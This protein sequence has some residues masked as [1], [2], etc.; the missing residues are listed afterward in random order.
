MPKR[1]STVKLCLFLKPTYIFI[2]VYV[3]SN[4]V[5][6]MKGLSYMK[7]ELPL[8]GDEGRGEERRLP[9]ERVRNPQR[10]YSTRS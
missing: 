1:F 8:P 9:M 4:N 10:A 2:Q 7:A 5:G 6:D 3:M